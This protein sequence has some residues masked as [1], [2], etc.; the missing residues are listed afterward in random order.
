MYRRVMSQYNGENVKRIPGGTTLH[1]LGS[2]VF[3]QPP[4]N[5]ISHISADTHVQSFT[6]NLFL[7][8][9]SFLRKGRQFCSAS[10]AGVGHAAR[11]SHNTMRKTH[12]INLSHLMIMSL[13]SG[14]LLYFSAT[15]TLS[16]IQDLEYHNHFYPSHP[17]LFFASEM[18]SEFYKKKGTVGLLTIS[19]RR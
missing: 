12:R 18:S 17:I 3:W 13:C 10:S 16:V 7:F 14:A 5:A 4:T 15:R 19:N 6:E 11:S 9:I 8:P 2:T 1:L